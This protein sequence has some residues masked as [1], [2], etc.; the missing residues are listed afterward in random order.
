MSN[1][2]F[3]KNKMCLSEGILFDISNNLMNKNLQSLTSRV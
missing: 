3:T 2:W 1:R